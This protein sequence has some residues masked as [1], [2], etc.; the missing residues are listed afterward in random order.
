MEQIRNKRVRTE[1]KRRE[2][3]FLRSMNLDEL[4]EASEIVEMGIKGEKIFMAKSPKA[5]QCA[6]V[7]LRLNE[8]PQTKRVAARMRQELTSQIIKEN[9]RTAD[10]VKGRRLYRELM[11]EK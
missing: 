1:G 6:R 9:R 2:P 11:A 10:P 7:I 3:S 4:L 5:E 8:Q